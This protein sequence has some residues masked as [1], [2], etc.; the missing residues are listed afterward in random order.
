MI[1]IIA[2]MIII[3]FIVIIKIMIMIMMII[4]IFA[5]AGH[6]FY[7]SPSDGTKSSGGQVINNLYDGAP[8]FAILT[9]LNKCDIGAKKI[10]C[11]FA[12][13]FEVI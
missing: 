4:T 9:L 12:S 13:W 10:F 3:I 8:L 7:H 11:D 6:G 5:G 1:I 2:I